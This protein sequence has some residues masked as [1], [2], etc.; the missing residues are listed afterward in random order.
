MAQLA[1]IERQMESANLG[2][3]I[4]VKLQARWWL[5][6]QEPGMHQCKTGGFAKVVTV[7]TFYLP[8]DQK[9]NIQQT[10]DT[11]VKY[12]NAGVINGWERT[13]EKATVVFDDRGDYV[14][15]RVTP[16]SGVLTKKDDDGRT[17]R[18]SVS[19]ARRLSDEHRQ[20]TSSIKRM[21]LE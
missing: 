13:V 20:R 9:I 2:K 19:D 21:T 5:P 12:Y 17:H 10:V 16:G 7:A 14:A 3:V 8:W 18:A 6:E 4:K 1:E 11:W 15:T